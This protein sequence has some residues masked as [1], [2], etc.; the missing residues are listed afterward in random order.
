MTG[1]L[2]Y[3]RPKR[4]RPLTSWPLVL[5]EA[6]PRLVGRLLAAPHRPLWLTPHPLPSLPSSSSSLSL[7]SLRAI[8]LSSLSLDAG[9]QGP[10]RK[11][12]RKELRLASRKNLETEDCRGNLLQN[13]FCSSPPCPQSPSCYFKIRPCTAFLDSTCVQCTT[14]IFLFLTYFTMY[15]WSYLQSRNRQM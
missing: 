9:T 5:K 8:R 11:R 12:E 15:R 2:E 4:G 3:N 7:A 14:F 13:A 6:L 1:I 10:C